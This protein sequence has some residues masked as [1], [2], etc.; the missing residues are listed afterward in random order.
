MIPARCRQTG[1][2]HV[3][4]DPGAAHDAHGAMEPQCGGEHDD[5]ELRG[6]G[7]GRHG[8]TF[9]PWYT[10]RLIR[11][12]ALLLLQLLEHVGDVDKR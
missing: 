7:F 6:L 1:L 2:Q 5:V 8:G 10:Q 3:A 12:A 4:D 11:S 9:V